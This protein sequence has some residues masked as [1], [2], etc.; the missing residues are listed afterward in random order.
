MTFTTDFITPV[1]SAKPKVRIDP[2][3]EKNAVFRWF[4]LQGENKIPTTPLFDMGDF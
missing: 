4:I 2:G 3:S 1:P